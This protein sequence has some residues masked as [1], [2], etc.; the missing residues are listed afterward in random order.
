MEQSND[1][2]DPLTSYVF[3]SIKSLKLFGI[4]NVVTSAGRPELIS[5]H[6]YKDTQFWWLLM[7]YNDLTSIDDIVPGMLIKYFNLK[8]LENL[9]FTL[10][11]QARAQEQA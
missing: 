9:Y 8:D 10:N 4:Y 2:F 3:K 6:I 11:S 7:L 5:Y 1:I